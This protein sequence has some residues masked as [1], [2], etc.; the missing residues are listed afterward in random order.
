MDKTRNR[1]T[2]KSLMLKCM[3]GGRCVLRQKRC[4]QGSIKVDV[5]NDPHSKDRS[6]SLV[7]AVTL[8][9]QLP[10]KPR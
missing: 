5:T 2:L 4:A 7:M 8:K 6:S 3:V 9:F 1:A 10:L